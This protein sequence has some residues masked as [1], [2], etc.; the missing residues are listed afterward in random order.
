MGGDSGPIFDRRRFLAGL[1]G[2]GLAV[3]AGRQVAGDVDA[4]TD[5]TPDPTSVLL[6]GTEHET[7]VYV[8]EGGDGPTAYVVGGVHGDER[9]GYLAASALAGRTPEAGTL[10]VLP[11]A[12]R[13]AIER[14][15]REGEE[16]DLNRNFPVGEDPESELASAIWRSIR[17]HDPDVVV[18]LHRSVGIYG[19][20]DASV[21]QAVFPVDVGRA[22]SAAERTVSTLNRRAVPWY[23]PLHDFRRGNAID[24]SRPMLVHKVAGD[25][26]RPGY[27]VETTRFLV[28]TATQARWLR[29]AAR[30]LLGRHGVSFSSPAEGGAR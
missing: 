16:G 25:Y 20:H 29:V 4:R 18:D 10:V 11:R 28:D 3:G 24:G 21:G 7:A 1:V 17:R 19:L 13:V 2:T 26:G 12:N 30:D 14:G 5:G 6:P 9:P 27:I 22:P 15:T 8:A 23:L